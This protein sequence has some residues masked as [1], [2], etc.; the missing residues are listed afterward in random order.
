MFLGC[1][2]CEAEEPLLKLVPDIV[3]ADPMAAALL[4]ECRGQTPEDLQVYPGNSCL[5][6]CLCLSQ[7]PSVVLALRNQVCGRD[8]AE[9]ESTAEVV[10]GG[11][12]LEGWHA[13]VD[14]LVVPV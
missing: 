8:S 11:L 4:V 12:V 5:Y 7:M 6:C 1:R 14:V 9:C 10:A 3:G 2:T 13:H